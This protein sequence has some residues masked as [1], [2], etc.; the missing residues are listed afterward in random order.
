MEQSWKIVGDNRVRTPARFM[1]FCLLGTAGTAVVLPASKGGGSKLLQVIALRG[2]SAP[3]WLDGK[4][5]GVRELSDATLPARLSKSL[6]PFLGRGSLVQ[7]SDVGLIKGISFL[8]IHSLANAGKKGRIRW[9]NRIAHLDV[10]IRNLVRH[11]ER[12][13]LSS[14]RFSTRMYS[15]ILKGSFEQQPL[16]EMRISGKIDRTT[17]AVQHLKDNSSIFFAFTWGEAM[18]QA[19]IPQK[20]AA[21]QETELPTKD[22][23][24][25]MPELLSKTYPSY[26]EELAGA[27]M[28]ST[29]RVLVV[30]DTHGKVQPGRFFILD[31]THAL[32]AESAMKSILN[33][34]RFRPGTLNGKAIKVL[35][36]I[37]ATFKISR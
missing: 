34:W 7:F 15:L 13:S 1:L 30:I 3:N 8:D 35:A 26:P 12:F 25:Q 37:E 5:Y 29:F 17:I 14:R 31:C 19:G 21:R 16:E 28:E 23:V 6:V 24:V 33:G 18:L 10:Q 27:G 32:F 36:Q 4:P 11:R 9:R 2:E 22:A 20:R